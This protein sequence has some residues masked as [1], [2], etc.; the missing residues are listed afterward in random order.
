MIRVWDQKK[1]PFCPY[2]A[3]RRIIHPSLVFVP[4]ISDN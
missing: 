3:P 1:L 2:E 4:V